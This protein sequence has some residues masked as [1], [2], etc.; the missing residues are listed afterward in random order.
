MRRQI[1]MDLFY[2][3][4]SQFVL[5]IVAYYGAVSQTAA[6]GAL[7]R[8]GQ[9]L[10]PVSVVAGAYVIPRF[11][12]ARDHLLRRYAGWMC[13]AS[14]PGCT[15]VLLALLWPSLLLKLV[16]SHYAGLTTEVA[17]ACLGAAIYSIAGI[18]WELL[19]N[20]GL[21]HFSFMQVPTVIV[22]SLAAPHL[23]DLTTLDGVLWFEAGLSSGLV[24]AV[25]CEIAAALRAGRLLPVPPGVPLSPVAEGLGHVPVTSA[26]APRQDRS[27]A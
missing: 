14:I 17:I 3:L 23:L 24:V 4:Q 18:A 16:G 13:L 15:L 6:I 9:L 1:P 2:C 27:A 12:L 19:A 20:R 21:N 7:S 5:G 10:V 26:E 22:W 8:I 11:A 25:L